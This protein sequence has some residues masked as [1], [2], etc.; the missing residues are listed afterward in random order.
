MSTGQQLKL[1]GME[2]A[3][4]HANETHESWSH[5]A[6]DFLIK[7]ARR[8]RTFLAEEVRNEAE[9]TGAVPVPP[10]KRAWGGIFLK[11]ASVGIIRK[12][13][14]KPVSNPKAHCAYATEWKSLIA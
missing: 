8:S 14:M 2:R 7:Y 3:E 5:K 12:N 10:S 9:E 1:E 11:A 6:H 13:G 4:E